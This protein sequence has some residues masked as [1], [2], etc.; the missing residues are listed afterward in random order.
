MADEE[1]EDEPTL[2]EICNLLAD[3]RKTVS[4]ILKDNK[5]LREDI[6]EMKSS[7]LKV[8]AVNLAR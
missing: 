2:T 3:V 1:S 8:S 7:E 6:A 4:D 5:S